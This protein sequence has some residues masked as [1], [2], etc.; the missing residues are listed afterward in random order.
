MDDYDK[1]LIHLRESFVFV[2][3]VWYDKVKPN[4]N[5][6]LR[7]FSDRMIQLDVQ[8]VRWS[9]PQSG[10]DQTSFVK[11]PLII[12]DAPARAK[13]Q[14]LLQFNGEYGCNTCEIKTVKTAAV[15][16]LRRIRVYPYVQ[17]PV[18]RTKAAMHNQA[19]EAQR[20]GTIVKDV[21]GPS[22]L[23]LIPSVD[24]SVC[25]IPEYM[26]GVLLGVEKH[27]LTIWSEVDEV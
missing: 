21:K 7:P 24:I 26:H 1:V 19:T 23:S 9:H 20:L 8:E 14:N 27:L 3:A 16:G 13:G 6:L 17:N 25:F 12:A 15:P 10:Q 5:T 22:V 4:M 2:A 18:L 11:V